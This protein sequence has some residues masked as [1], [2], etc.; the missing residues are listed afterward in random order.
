MMQVKHSSTLEKKQLVV[1][2]DN[3]S[4]EKTLTPISLGE[5]FP[6]DSSTMELLQSVVWFP[7]MKT[8]MKM[9]LSKKRTPLLLGWTNPKKRRKR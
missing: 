6:Q 1:Q 9:K 3:L 8:L 5:Y 7:A 2:V 4:K